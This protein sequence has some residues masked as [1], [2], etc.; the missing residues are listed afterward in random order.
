MGSLITGNSVGPYD[1]SI[2]LNTSFTLNGPTHD[3]TPVPLCNS[4]G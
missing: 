1:N 2:Y 3:F 4:E